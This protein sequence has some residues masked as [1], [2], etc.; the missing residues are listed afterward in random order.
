MDYKRA[1]ILVV[2]DI[3]VLAELCVAIWWGHLVP[4]EIT[5]RFV[6]VFLPVVLITLWL[7]RLAFKRWA[8]K[9]CSSEPSPYRRVGLFGPLDDSSNMKITKGA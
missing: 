2:A 1:L 6:Q 8:P 4:E 5:W 9:S 3:V 7:T